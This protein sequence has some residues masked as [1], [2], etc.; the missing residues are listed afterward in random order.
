MKNKTISAKEKASNQIKKTIL[1]LLAITAIGQG[2]FSYVKDSPSALNLLNSNDEVKQNCETLGVDYSNLEMAS[3]GA[4]KY[5]L[6]GKED[7]KSY[8]NIPINRCVPEIGNVVKV[9]I[10]KNFSK[11]YQKLIIECVNEINYIAKNI[12]DPICYEVEIGNGKE[13]RECDITVV[14][15]TEAKI[16]PNEKS[17]SGEAKGL[18]YKFIN[19]VLTCLYPT[20]E[21]SYEENDKNENRFQHTVMHEF[22]HLIYGARDV[23]MKKDKELSIS[24]FEEAKSFRYFTTE[25]FFIKKKVYDANIEGSIINDS[26]FYSIGD[27]LLWSAKNTKNLKENEEKVRNFAKKYQ[28]ECIEYELKKDYNQ[29]SKYQTN[30]ENLQMVRERFE[31]NI[32]NFLTLSEEDL[33]ILEFYNFLNGQFKKLNIEEKTKEKI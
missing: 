19:G 10:D 15:R 11:Q 14:K 3:I 33:F 25:D 27:I 4:I 8:L 2:V 21:L 13:R 29:V 6:T 22:A 24:N 18:S 1:S 26:P 23:F 9:F 20:M 16:A 5:Y 30:L 32:S 12:G 28:A 17:I 31:E 7:N